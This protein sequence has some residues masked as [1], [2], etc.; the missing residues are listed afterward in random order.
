[1]MNRR[2]FLSFLAGL[3]V[4]GRYWKPK[5]RLPKIHFV[6]QDWGWGETTGSI[7]NRV[8]AP[9]VNVSDVTADKPHE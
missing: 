3:P 8:P 6:T 7:F 2:F 4:I 9:T 1:M 5:L